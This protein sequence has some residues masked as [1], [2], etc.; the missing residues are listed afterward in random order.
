MNKF[1]IFFL[2]I[3]IINILLIISPIEFSNIEN[4]K[5]LIVN[6]EIKEDIIINIPYV[7]ENKKTSDFYI[8]NKVITINNLDYNIL[9]EYQNNDFFEEN[10]Y[11]YLT[12]KNDEYKYRIFSVLR[13]NVNYNNNY[14]EYLYSLQN[15]SLFN[16]NYQFKNEDEI[17][18]IK[19]NNNLILTGVLTNN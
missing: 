15:S 6:K 10:S 1:K 3:I 7:I 17:I 19:T 18:I 2:L 14:L 13:Q 12:F 16:I 9:K 5:D 4:G 8:E 11:I